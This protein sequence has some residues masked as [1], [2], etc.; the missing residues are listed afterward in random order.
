MINTGQ[1]ALTI[2]NGQPPYTVTWSDGINNTDTAT[3][4]IA[5]TYTATVTD[6]N[7]CSTSI[8]ET[9]LQADSINLIINAIDAAC[10]ADSTGSI[11]I[12]VNGGLAPYSFLWDNNLDTLQ[13]Q[14]NLPSNTYNVTVTDENN[15]T[16]STS[17]FIDEPTP[18]TAT[19]TPTSTSYIYT[20]V[21][22]DIYT[23]A[24]TGTYI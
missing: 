1:I 6:Q 23:D 10:S 17:I 15:C 9:V 18:L 4:L 24:G 20:S 11:D 16:V 21:D 2:N 13:N 19:P 22:A 8:Q 12:T 7:G 5:G 3:A 14:I